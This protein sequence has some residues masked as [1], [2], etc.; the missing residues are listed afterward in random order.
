MERDALGR[1]ERSERL[2]RAAVTAGT[3]ARR[4][5]ISSVTWGTIAPRCIS[6]RPSPNR[7]NGYHEALVTRSST[8]VYWCLV[9]LGVFAGC[10]IGYDEIPFIGDDFGGGGG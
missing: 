2:S 10:R 6:D 8:L 5:R 9:G 3:C 7:E 4:L 1:H